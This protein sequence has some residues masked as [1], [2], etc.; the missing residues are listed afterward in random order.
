MRIRWL[1]IALSG[2]CFGIVAWYSPDLWAKV[3]QNEALNQ[4]INETS[5]LV[6]HASRLWDGL[7]CL[8]WLLFCTL[9]HCRRVSTAVDNTLGGEAYTSGVSWTSFSAGCSVAPVKRLQIQG[10]LPYLALLA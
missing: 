6:Q 9:W 5:A 2:L 10:I 1:A 8:Q 7:G 3:G 4:P